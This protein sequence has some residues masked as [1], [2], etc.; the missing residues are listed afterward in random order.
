MKTMYKSTPISPWVNGNVHETRESA[1][2]YI[3]SYIGGGSVDEIQV[4]DRPISACRV[5]RSCAG[6]R[7]VLLVTADVLE[8][9]IADCVDWADVESALDDLRDIHGADQIG[10]LT[11]YLGT[12]GQMHVYRWLDG[13]VIVPAAKR[14]NGNFFAACTVA[15]ASGYRVAAIMHSI[16]G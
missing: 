15:T 14:L 6:D 9:A 5:E 10:L 12:D 1:E 11:Q 4:D 16:V 7:K 13:C 8:S 2:A 3:S